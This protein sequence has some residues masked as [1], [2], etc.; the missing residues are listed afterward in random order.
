MAQLLCHGEDLLVLH[1]PD[2]EGYQWCS[3]VYGIDGF[4]LGVLHREVLA[5]ELEVLAEGIDLTGQ[6]SQE[7]QG[8]TGFDK[9]LQALLQPIPHEEK[10]GVV[11]QV[12]VKVPIGLL[13]G[14]IVRVLQPLGNGAW[15]HGVAQ[16]ADEAIA[17]QEEVQE[18]PPAVGAE[19]QA[20]FGAGGE[21]SQPTGAQGGVDTP[22]SPI[23]FLNF[24]WAIHGEHSPAVCHSVIIRR[25]THAENGNAYNEHHGSEVYRDIF[26]VPVH[27][28]PQGG[29]NKQ[30]P[31]NAEFPDAALDG[32][33]I[34]RVFLLLF[35]LLPNHIFRLLQGLIHR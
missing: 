27:A 19:N 2:P 6:K 22:K 31:P 9:V 4:S 28:D 7:R 29:G 32:G 11:A 14:G 8:R 34:I 10:V 20:F 26:P 17:A 18:F 5:R 13:L 33:R 15:Q 30:E 12:L 23:E 24:S 16:I 21:F 3:A 35:L 1:I 25:G